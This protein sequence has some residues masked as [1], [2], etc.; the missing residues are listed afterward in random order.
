MV[1]RAK[2]EDDDMAWHEY[3]LDPVDVAIMELLRKDSRAPFVKIGQH[4]SL[5]AG[6][7][8]A[9]ITK[10]VD[11]RVLRIVGAVRP[12]SLGFDCLATSLFTYR[13]D[14]AAL[15]AEFQE[16]PNITFMAQL[17]NHYNVLCEI[18]A[19]DDVELAEIVS[20][21]LLSREQVDGFTIQRHLEVFKWQT[22]GW[23]PPADATSAAAAN[24]EPDELDIA[25]LWALVETPRASFKELADKVGEP[26]WAV[27][28][29]TQALFADGLINATAMMDKLSTSPECMA[30]IGITL[31]GDMATGVKTLTK[32]P[33]V[34]LLLSTSGDANL[35]CEVTCPTPQDLARITRKICALK[36]V[37]AV[38]CRPYARILKVPIPWR[39]DTV[40]LD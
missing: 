25:L 5:S 10:L 38:V 6:A 32:M 17:T 24:R 37:G 12:E 19:S 1:A 39:F 2:S 23:L 36:D 11:D 4:V 34:K 35:S 13:G 8:N 20:E 22:Q 29:R 21:Q 3:E 30:S 18:G 9:R 7:V 40:R 33:E 28:K 31:R 27:R 15:A 26:Y 16:H 14:V